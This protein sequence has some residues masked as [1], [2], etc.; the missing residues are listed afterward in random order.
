MILTYI[1]RCLNTKKTKISLDIDFC[2]IIVRCG[3]DPSFEDLED[4]LYYLLDSY[5]LRGIAIEYDEINIEDVLN[6]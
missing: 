2:K 5:Q 4:L 1:S 6:F 3:P